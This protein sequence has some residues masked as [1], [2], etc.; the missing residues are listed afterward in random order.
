MKMLTT[1]QCYAMYQRERKSE[2][3]EKIIMQ[4]QHGSKFSGSKNQTPTG[5]ALTF[6]SPT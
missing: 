4:I 3:K 6:I 5:R 1:T 2:E